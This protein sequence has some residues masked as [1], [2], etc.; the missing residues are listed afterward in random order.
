MK[1]SLSRDDVID[2]LTS[3]RGNEGREKSV[4][5]QWVFSDFFELIE[6]PLFLIRVVTR[7]ESPSYTS[8]PVILDA[9]RLEVTRQILPHFQ[10]I[11]GVHR[12]SAALS[13]G[14]KDILAYVGTNA[15]PHIERF[16][17]LL[18]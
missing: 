12:V 4:F 8:A 9:P 3:H 11:D 16:F 1:Q 18:S 17:Q 15:I 10:I 14:E 5:N 13:R 6:T 2:I 7:D